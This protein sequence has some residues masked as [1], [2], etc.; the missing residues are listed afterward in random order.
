MAYKPDDLARVVIA[1]VSL[2][3][4]VEE[5][6]AVLTPDYIP[7]QVSAV[8]ISRIKEHAWQFLAGTRDEQF[9]KMSLIAELLTAKVRY[10]YH[11]ET[12]CM[13]TQVC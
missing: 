10:T 7:T 12:S 4:S 2:R 1:E 8:G 5:I 6:R 13:Y 11:L 9:G 3:K